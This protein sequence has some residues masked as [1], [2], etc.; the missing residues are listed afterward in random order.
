MQSWLGATVFGILLE[1]LAMKGIS[2]EMLWERFV[3]FS[4]D[5]TAG[6]TG[7][8]RGSSHTPVWKI[9]PNLTIIYCINHKLE[10][11]V[12]DGAEHRAQS[13]SHILWLSH[14]EVCCWALSVEQWFSPSLCR[15]L[16]RCEKNRLKC[17]R[18]PLTGKQKKISHQSRLFS[19][20]FTAVGHLFEFL[21]SFELKSRLLY[22][23]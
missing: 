23:C 7:A 12:N 3:C 10:L 11:V 16:N 6:L 4:T 15:N 17:L 20:E 18:W 14:C 19:K 1:P 9:N 13:F 2:E 8:Y 22:C 5:G 21:W